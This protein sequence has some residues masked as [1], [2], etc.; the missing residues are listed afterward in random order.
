MPE[1]VTDRRSCHK[2]HKTV[3]GK[4]KLSKCAQCHSITYCGQECQ[5]E[6]WPR[7][8]Q[9]CI[10]VMV[11]E[12]PGKGK[13]LVAS[14]DI[15]KGQVIFKETAA[16]AVHAPSDIVPLQEMKEQ[17]SKMSVEQKSKFYQLPRDGAFNP[18][19]LAAASRENC[20]QELDIFISNG[21]GIDTDK[22]TLYLFINSSLLNHSCAPNATMEKCGDDLQL[23]CTWGIHLL[24]SFATGTF[25]FLLHS[26]QRRVSGAR[27]AF[28]RL[29]LL[30][31]YS[32]L[33]NPHC[34]SCLLE[35]AL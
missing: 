27:Y 28:Q 17:I 6:D 32:Y 19:Q 14:K 15:K 12:I 2:C 1:D 20:L 13:G 26:C 35:G 24:V 29:N 8:S 31:H 33:P 18:L 21:C 22:D 7:H 34:V 23:V 25:V 4:R 16:I 3:T 9:F 30:V 10:P 11:T 5:R